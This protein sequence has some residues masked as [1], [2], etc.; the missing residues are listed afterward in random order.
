[1]TP[2][3]AICLVGDVPDKGN[4]RD[5]GVPGRVEC[6][7]Q[8]MPARFKTCPGRQLYQPLPL[9]GS[10]LPDN[11]GMARKDYRRGAA[12]SGNPKLAKAIR[13]PHSWRWAAVQRGSELPGGNRTTHAT[14][15]YRTMPEW[16]PPPALHATDCAGKAVSK[17]LAKDK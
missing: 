6:K 2:K 13:P 16:S 12:L 9:T 1:M 15:C 3:L 17:T 10:G 7:H 8:P 14:Q 11:T 4:R 5:K